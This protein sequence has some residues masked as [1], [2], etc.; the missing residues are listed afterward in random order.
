MFSGGL[1][2]R[3]PKQEVA[4]GVGFYIR[5]GLDWCALPDEVDP[6]LHSIQI[7]AQ[8][9]G[10]PNVYLAAFYSA[11][12][13]TKEERAHCLEVLST[14]YEKYQCRGLTLI[15]GD[16]NGNGSSGVSM[17]RDWLQSGVICLNA[18]DDEVES[19]ESKRSVEVPGWHDLPMLATHTAGHVLDCF[20]ASPATVAWC[21]GF[22][23]H[24]N[25]I[26][27]GHKCGHF[28]I[29]VRLHIEPNIVAH[30]QHHVTPKW[31]S[32]D[33][34]AVQERLTE[35]MADALADLVIDTSCPEA[36]EKSSKALQETLLK[37]STDVVGVRLHRGPRTWVDREVFRLTKK[38]AALSRLAVQHHR[39][40]RMDAATAIRCEIWHMKR[41]IR[42]ASRAA[43][44]QSIKVACAH[45]ERLSDRQFWRRVAQASSS[46]S[47]IPRAMRCAD[48]SLVTEAEAKL[49]VMKEA[50]AIIYDEQR[51]S[52][53]LWNDEAWM[54]MKAD[55]AK[56]LPA[57]VKGGEEGAA[58]VDK[59]RVIEAVKLL[60]SSGAAG[61]D[62]IHPWMVKLAGPAII[63]P[64]TQLFS[65]IWRLCYL[66]EQW[67]K[68]LI[69][70]IFKKGDKADPG[71]YR[72]ICLLSV[73]AKLF[74]RVL[75]D[76][77]YVRLEREGLIP[78]VQ[79]GF[80]SRRGCPEKVFGLYSVLENRWRCKK[81]TYVSFVDVKK[82]Y[83]SVSRSALLLRL[84]D[85]QTPDH[86]W[87]M[88]REVYTDDSACIL[89][90]DTRSDWFR[91]TLG[92]R[93][94]DV[95]SPI[96]YSCFI[97]AVVPEIQRDASHGVDLFDEKSRLCI[98]LFA[99][100]M[101]LL[102][103]SAESLQSM[104]NVLSDFAA[105]N[106]FKIS[107][108]VDQK[109]SAVMIYGGDEP[110]VVEP[111][112]LCGDSLPLV[113][114]Y[115]Y[116][117]VII[118]R[119]GSWAPHLA[120]VRKRFSKRLFDLRKA[121]MSRDG[122][123]P[124]RARSLVWSHL[125]PLWEYACAALLLSKR[126]T[127]MLDTLF[128]SAVRTAA[129]VKR[130]VSVEPLLR[131]M[132][133]LHALPSKRVQMYRINLWHKIRGMQA[134]RWVKRAAGMWFSS[135]KVRMRSPD[136]FIGRGYDCYG[137]L[138]PHRGKLPQLPPS[139]TDLVFADLEAFGLSR[140]WDE[141]VELP[142]TDEWKPMI[143]ERMF[144]CTQKQWRERMNQKPH[145]AAYA[146]A[147]QDVGFVD[148][149]Y[150]VTDWY[151]RETKMVKVRRKQKTFCSRLH[152]PHRRR[153][154]FLLYLRAGSLPLQ[155]PK[156][157]GL[158]YYRCGGVQGSSKCF[159]CPLEV[160]ET[161]EHFVCHCP[162]YGPTKNKYLRQPDS[163]ID[164]DSVFRHPKKHKEHILTLFEMWK[165]R[166]DR[167]RRSH[168]GHC[169][170]FL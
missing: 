121:G 98:L 157:S 16:F 75:N 39:A 90:G 120:S 165:F 35:S 33:E 51:Y 44:K 119:H 47:D 149:V 148:R 26:V 37:V 38:R 62:Q 152:S 107:S 60:R 29:S 93:Q 145:L 27:G 61:L 166:M 102:A 153:R 96:L 85:L 97:N 114:R 54:A 115:C 32:V 125:C 168:R 73:V 50:W 118:E 69:I 169:A 133:L 63:E 25:E 59:H 142:P 87:A 49:R 170:D 7:Y 41:A 116:L 137:Q 131:D 123:P 130:Y 30:Q 140:L 134:D 15:Y 103:E 139:W 88:V 150:P 129:G 11:P 147:V 143:R 52:S 163:L 79:G 151:S 56:R 104:L 21:S 161:L 108:G 67:K 111:F 105:L 64:L 100:D 144:T 128:Y 13:S 20:F 76:V 82:A 126:D 42:S 14:W 83:D 101:C 40:G 5:E 84:L 71:N 68:G 53:S 19:K 86:V 94:G 106:R 57:G 77:L 164:L 34:K 55:V 23:V 81:Q 138:L 92:V 10:M 156:H 117:G 112:Q 9:E 3:S 17:M 162:A 6:C 124:W 4:R 95:A 58:E 159:M 12:N 132:D 160:D 167:W 136:R 158:H 109:K 91:T 2:Y 65:G 146:R 110:V 122:L 1:E 43:R 135:D 127:D 113:S 28:P 80:R 66:P 78:D 74:T 24:Q 154:Q 31:N 46:S 36:I 45:L 22:A 155:R 99:D 89:M 48:G 72:P 141:S 18:G 70:P 8:G